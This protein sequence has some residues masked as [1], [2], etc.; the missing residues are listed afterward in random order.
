VFVSK[1]KFKLQELEAHDQ[2]IL[3][4]SDIS[5]VLGVFGNIMRYF[6]QKH[7]E[8][9]ILTGTGQDWTGH[10]AIHLGLLIYVFEL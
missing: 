10:V 7:I 3:W 8:A 5:Q 9:N 1:I 2:D 4:Y 6:A